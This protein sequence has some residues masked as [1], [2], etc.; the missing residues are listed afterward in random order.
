[1]NNLP[2]YFEVPKP[3]QSFLGKALTVWNFNYLRVAGL[4]AGYG[5]ECISEH[6]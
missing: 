1:V 4:G 3:F 5:Q 2:S 6:F